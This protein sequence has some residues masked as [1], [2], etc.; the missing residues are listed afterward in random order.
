MTESPTHKCLGKN[1]ESDPMQYSSSFFFCIPRG[2]FSFFINLT[3]EGSHQFPPA[4]K[5][6]YCPLGAP[7]LLC[8]GMFW[9]NL[10]R[11]RSFPC[12][13]SP[14]LCFSHYS[15]VNFPTIYKGSHQP[16]PTMPPIADTHQTLLAFASDL[17]REAENEILPRFRNVAIMYKIRRFGSHRRG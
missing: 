11:I 8:K 17:A 9:Y 2:R 15:E 5:R 1:E 10:W 13:P 3:R 7:L 6:F 12:T 16:H 4:G 14:P